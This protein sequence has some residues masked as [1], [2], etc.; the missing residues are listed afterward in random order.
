MHEAEAL[1]LFANAIRRDMAIEFAHGVIADGEEAIHWVK[2]Q[3]LYAEVVLASD[4]WDG[5]TC[6][7]A[8]GGSL[9]YATKRGR[10]HSEPIAAGDHVIVVLI[11]GD[12]NGH[13][14]IIS[15]ASGAHAEPE[16]EVAFRGVHEI[17]LTK[18]H[19]DKYEK[20]SGHL[21]EYEDG[22]VFTRLK[23]KGN[24]TVKLPDGSVIDATNDAVNGGYQLKLKHAGGA[25][26][27]VNANA[28]QLKSPMGTSWLQVSDKGID[29]VGPY[30][31]T[32]SLTFLS[33]DKEVGD[34]PGLQGVAYGRPWPTAPAPEPSGHSTRVYVGK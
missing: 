16:A 4:P 26:V 11:E 23:G 22:S 28:V 10:L 27:L 5:A 3:G 18:H 2:G 31:R 8:V 14:V 13:C 12:P 34:A 6:K 33:L 1:G 25:C 15:R 20:G 32:K 30:V 9:F 29:L 7:A 21:I 17:N 19:F 24:Y